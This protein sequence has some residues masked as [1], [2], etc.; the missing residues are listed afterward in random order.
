MIH[1][2]E[3]QF[4]NWGL[5]NIIQVEKCYWC[6]LGENNEKKVMAKA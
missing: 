3:K 5:E 2:Q 6:F 1:G 4:Y